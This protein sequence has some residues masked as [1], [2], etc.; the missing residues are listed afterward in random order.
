[1]KCHSDAAALFDPIVCARISPHC[2]QQIGLSVFIQVIYIQITHTFVFKRR[3]SLAVL[4]QLLSKAA[5]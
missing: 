1:M 4:L 3:I 2:A 5:S